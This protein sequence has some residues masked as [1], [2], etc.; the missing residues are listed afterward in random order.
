[1][2]ARSSRFWRQKGYAAPGILKVSTLHRYLYNAGVGVNE[3][4]E[5]L[6]GEERLPRDD[7]VD[8]MEW[9]FYRKIPSMNQIVD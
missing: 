5:T 9:S 8:H 3:A 2:S 7:S 4:D 6:Y 1:M